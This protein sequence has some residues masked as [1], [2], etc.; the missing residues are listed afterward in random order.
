[1]P[2]RPGSGPLARTPIEPPRPDPPLLGP[3]LLGPGLLE[4]RML[5]ARLLAARLLGLQSGAAPRAPR[6][7]APGLPAA[8]LLGLQSGAALRA[9]RSHEPGWR[10]ARARGQGSGAALRALYAAFL[11]RAPIRNRLARRPLDHIL[12]APAETAAQRM[13]RSSKT[14][15]RR[16]PP[17]QTADPSVYSSA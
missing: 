11:P 3:R 14:N 10:E 15:E 4:A 16:G 2:P 13:T 5:E 17:E 6:L 12:R 1:M 9:Q 7:L 8:Q